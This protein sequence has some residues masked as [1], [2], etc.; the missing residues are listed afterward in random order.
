MNRNGRLGGK[1]DLHVP[2]NKKI[3]LGEPNELEVSRSNFD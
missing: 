1:G 3:R 2:K